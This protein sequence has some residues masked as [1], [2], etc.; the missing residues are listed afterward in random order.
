MGRKPGLACGQE[1][2]K[3]DEDGMV[4]SKQM[5]MWPGGVGQASGG[6]TGRLG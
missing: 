2:Q 6:M 1:R 3:C 4:G 5:E